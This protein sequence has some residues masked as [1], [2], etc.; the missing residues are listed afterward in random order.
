MLIF[1]SKSEILTFL[2]TPSDIKD[3]VEQLKITI[4][5][6][7]LEDIYNADETGLFLQTP[8]DWT[9]DNQKGQEPRYRRPVYQ[10]FFAP[11]PW[12]QTK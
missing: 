9:I 10:S 12:E 8:S 11:M 6:Y 2:A 1:F 7:K 4:A 3:K 5:A